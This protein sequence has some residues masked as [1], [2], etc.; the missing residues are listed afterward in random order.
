ME[1]A[2][3]M[4]DLTPDQIRQTRDALQD[5]VDQ[6]NRLLMAKRKELSQ[7]DIDRINEAVGKLLDASDRLTAQAIK[8][9]AE[10]IAD[11]VQRIQDATN[12]ANHTLK[13]LDSI[14]KG[15]NVAAALVGLGAAIMAG[16]PGGIVQASAGVIE[17]ARTVIA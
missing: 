7:D 4:P 8:G 3:T 9:T 11:S 13:V 12:N 16:N 6:L 5:T 10:E 15:I 2:E 17:A 14:R 1:V